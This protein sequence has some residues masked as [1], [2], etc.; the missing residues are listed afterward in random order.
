MTRRNPNPVLDLDELLSSWLRRLRGDRKSAQ[1]LRSYRVA[2]EA[3]LQYCDDTDRPREL[4]KQ[5]VVA[6]IESQHER[7]S[8]T[9]RLRLI[10]LKQ[11][12]KWL[13]AEEDFDADGIV[14]IAPPKLSQAAV[15]GLTDNEVQ[16]M[17]KIC[18][19][20]QLRDKRDKA[21]LRLLVET[22][23]RASEC[24]GLD[25]TDIN[26]DACLLQVRKAKGGKSKDRRVG[27]S[28]ET[29]SA[30]DR[31]VRARRVAILRPA[32]GPLWLSE[33]GNRLTY[34]GLVS[35]L[36]ERASDAGVAD[37]HIHAL[38]HSAAIRWLHSGGT[39]VGLMAH[40]GWQDR[41]MV[42]R[43]VRSASEQLA[44]EE[45]GRLNLSLADL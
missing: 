15:A 14:V 3:Y 23:L 6:W 13:S 45:F 43:Y 42:A 39:E 35:S 16:R 18:S 34:T 33:R 2:V 32:E 4:T 36:K 38:R 12:A 27:F 7:A 19:G 44:S 8:A 24:L 25:I 29:A 9:V 37:F 5:N 40:C 10:A 21:I 26:L 31:Y 22:G 28:P 41:S 17:V 20:S 1:T 30:V 11:F